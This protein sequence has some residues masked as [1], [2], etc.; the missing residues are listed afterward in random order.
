MFLA[1]SFY[2]FFNQKRSRLMK[3]TSLKNKL[4]FDN[5]LSHKKLFGGKPANDWKPPSNNWLIATN[6]SDA[7]CWTNGCWLVEGDANLQWFFWWV[8]I[9]QA[10]MLIFTCVKLSSMLPPIRIHDFFRS[11]FRRIRHEESI[12]VIGEDSGLWSVLWTFRQRSLSHTQAIDKLP[13][14]TH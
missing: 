7:W 14:P 10:L 9:M 11:F 2:W 1:T 4:N 5:P 6:F 3:S 12:P 8:P 13:D